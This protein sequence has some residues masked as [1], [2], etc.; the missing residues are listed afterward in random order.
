M[1]LTKDSRYHLCIGLTL[2]KQEN[3]PEF[4]TGLVYSG[5]SYIQAVAIQDLT[6]GYYSEISE[7]LAPLRKELIEAGY[8]QAALVEPEVSPIVRE[9]I[10][11]VKG[12][13]KPAT[14]VQ[15]APRR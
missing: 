6:D 3:P 4:S 10:N 2:A 12:K 13:G 5:L 7:V 14:P 1:P 9:T 15:P 8:A 11:G